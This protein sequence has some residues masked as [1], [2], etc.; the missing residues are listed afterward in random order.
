[1]FVS[2]RHGAQATEKKR[3]ICSKSRVSFLTRRL[4][5]N[6]FGSSIYRLRHLAIHSVVSRR[7]LLCE[8]NLELIFDHAAYAV[9]TR[10]VLAKVLTKHNHAHRGSGLDFAARRK[11]AARSRWSQKEHEAAVKPPAPQSRLEPNG[12]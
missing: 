1:M 5:S 4:C 11:Q 9:S 6:S 12:A 3:P 8:A 10:R 7:L 2:R